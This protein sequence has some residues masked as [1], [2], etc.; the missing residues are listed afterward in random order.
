MD[1]VFLK[2][3]DP[4][5]TEHCGSPGTPHFAGRHTS[6]IH[7]LRSGWFA[8]LLCF[9]G[10]LV[11]L[12]VVS[13][14]GNVSSEDTIA[15]V[16]NVPVENNVSAAGNVMEEGPPSVTGTRAREAPEEA[17][18]PGDTNTTTVN[19]TKEYVQ[20]LEQRGLNCYRKHDYTCAWNYYEAV[21]QAN[22]EAWSPIY[23]ESLIL[24]DNGNL[25]GAIDKMDEVLTRV[26]DSA[27]VWKSNL[28]K[29]KGDLLNRAGRY[30]ES[31]ASYNRAKALNPHIS[32]PL[33]NWF[34]YNLG[35]KNL[36]LFMIAFGFSC[37]GVYVYF[38]EFRR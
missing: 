8:V 7:L 33:T 18:T 32:I 27:I 11:F 21:H 35:I 31:D 26:P 19:N 29:L 3:F 5:S 22:P 2:S 38:R 1:G 25:T 12:P 10:V 23:V 4:D 20:D 24:A 13:A 6:C 9:F 37:L 17:A 28:W 15:A 16:G 14:A 34:P 36:T 30:T